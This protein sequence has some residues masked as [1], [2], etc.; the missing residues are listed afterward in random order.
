MLTI[1]WKYLGYSTNKPFKEILPQDENKKFVD[2]SPAYSGCFLE[3]GNK[4]RRLSVYTKN[5]RQQQ[6]VFK[7]LISLPDES[8]SKGSPHIFI[9]E[10]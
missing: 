6:F 3:Y 4:L 9:N 8:V 7:K 2:Y 10:L 1:S 5:H